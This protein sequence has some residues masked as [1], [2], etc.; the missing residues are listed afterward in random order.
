MIVLSEIETDALAE[1]AN[2][3]V[4]K[5]S[6]ALSRM[7]GDE[8][9]MSV[10]TV[11]VVPCAEAARRFDAEYAGRLVAVSER[12]SGPMAGVALLVVPEASSLELVRAALPDEVP[13]DEAGALAPEALAEVGNI[14][15]NNCLSSMANMLGAGLDTALPR[16]LYGNGLEVFAQCGAGEGSGAT[17]IV[18]S[19]RTRMK[20]RNVPAQIVVAV[21]TASEEALRARLAAYVERVLG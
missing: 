20:A 19:V 5:A 14:V 6:V 18:F 21:D 8:V 13:P 15:L 1:L 9:A 12:F 7:V 17:A 4:S 3:G 10:P 11:E 2:I 16:V